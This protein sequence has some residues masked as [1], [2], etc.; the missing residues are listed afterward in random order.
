[1]PRASPHFWQGPVGDRAALSRQG[2]SLRLALVTPRLD[3]RHRRHHPRRPPAAHPPSHLGKF[4]AGY[5]IDF[6]KT[7]GVHIDAISLQNEL[8]FSEFYDSCIYTPDT[9]RDTVAAVGAEM[10]K[11]GCTTQLMGP[12]MS[13]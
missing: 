9:F 7:F 10:K 2:Q 4:I 5:C 13:R 12:E 1:M 3:D 11:W 6:E 8:R